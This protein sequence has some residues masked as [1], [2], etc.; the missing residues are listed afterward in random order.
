MSVLIVKNYSSPP[1]N[2]SKIRKDAPALQKGRRRFFSFLRLFAK[3]GNLILDI[4]NAFGRPGHRQS[5]FRRER[6]PQK[7]R[8][9]PRRK[10]Q[11]PAPSPTQRSK[12]PV[13]PP[14]KGRR[15]GDEPPPRRGNPLRGRKNAGQRWRSADNPSCVRRAGAAP[16]QSRRKRQTAGEAAGSPPCR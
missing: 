7:P 4:K 3:S 8:E 6:A 14:S 16:A 15:R 13:R 9:P 12:R 11:K 1:K 10:K 5:A 2:F